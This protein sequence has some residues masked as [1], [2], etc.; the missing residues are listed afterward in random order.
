MGLLFEAIV[1][2]VVLALALALVVSTSG[3]IV[4]VYHALIVGFATGIVVHLGF[5]VSGANAAYC[6]IGAACR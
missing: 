2:G 4:T 1:V 6:E 5:E 3:P